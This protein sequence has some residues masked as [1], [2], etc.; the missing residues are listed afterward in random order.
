MRIKLAHSP[1]SDDAFMFYAIL[2][3]KIDLKNYEFENNLADIETLN[4]CALEEIYDLT[5]VSYNAYTKVHNKYQILK[6]GS[7]IGYGYGPILIC[8]KGDDI[9][10]IKRLISLAKLKVLSPGELTSAHLTLQLAFPQADFRIEKFNKIKDLILNGTER[11]GLIIHETQVTFE[12]DNLEKVLDLG[13]WWSKETNGLVLPLGVNIIKRSLTTEVK[14]DLSEILKKSIE[15]SLNNEDKALEF[16]SNYASGLDLIKL[17]RFVS[18]YVNH[19]T[20]NLEEL[21]IKSIQEFYKRA[22]SLQLIKE[23]PEL[24]II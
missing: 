14:K 13:E 16:A 3:K 15:Y 12:D 11:V 18:M 8:R 24:D 5:A 10:E 4:K 2:N 7:S 21:E 22:F 9:E 17:K 20:L 1:D 19:K 6:A 23:I